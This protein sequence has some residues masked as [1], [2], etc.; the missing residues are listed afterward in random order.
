MKLKTTLVALCLLGAAGCS[1][2][3]AQAESK[4]KAA[5]ACKD[6]ACTRPYIQWFNEQS[7]K[8]NG[9]AIKDLSAEASAR[10][11]ALS[12]KAGECQ[13]KLKLGGT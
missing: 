13:M 2:I 8:G 10:Y 4:A 6:A 12:I 11:R 7:L 9:A 5:C 3:V 1:D